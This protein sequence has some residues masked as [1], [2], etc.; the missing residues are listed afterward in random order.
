M[1]YLCAE[2]ALKI[3]TM[4]SN[5]KLNLETDNFVHLTSDVVPNW[6]NT[7]ELIKDKIQAAIENSNTKLEGVK[8]CKPI[9]VPSK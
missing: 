5:E 3:K 6:V 4:S 8:F 2:I 1:N 7:L 9:D